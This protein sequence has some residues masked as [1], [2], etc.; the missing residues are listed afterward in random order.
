M[1]NGDGKGGECEIRINSSMSDMRNDKRR[2]IFNLYICVVE[3][4]Y[5]GRIVVRVLCT[6]YCRWS[7]IPRI[8][9]PGIFP[10]LVYYIFA[11]PGLV[12]CGVSFPSLPDPSYT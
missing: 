12:E 9:L 5:E 3:F 11:F 1:L 4:K 10:H 2:I 6:P 7:E 8:D